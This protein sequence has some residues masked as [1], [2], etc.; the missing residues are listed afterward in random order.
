[1]SEKVSIIIPNKNQYELLKDCIDSIIQNTLYLDY[2]ILIIENG[3]SD[4]D[5]LE[6]YRHLR[7][8]HLDISV[9]P[10]RKPFNFSEINNFAVNQSNG[11]YLLFLNNDTKVI[12]SGWLTEMVNNLKEDDIGA[13]GAALLYK[14]E[15]IQ[16]I[17]VT[18]HPQYVAFHHNHNSPRSII[19][20]EFD[21]PKIVDAVTGA[22]LLTSKYI[23]KEVDGFD[24]NLPL[25][26]NDV[27]FCMKLRDKGYK[28]KWTPD[29][30]LYHYESKTRGYEDTPEKMDKLIEASNY[31]R[32]K[33]KT[34]LKST[35]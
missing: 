32:N 19:Q 3:S 12:N 22:C 5:I 16:H 26:Y 6:Y 34:K 21:S 8:H 4:A 27:D 15:K 2:E 23:F 9:I 13:V 17:G 31:M 30:L 7:R 24:E 14:D 20:E 33:W 11:K 29:C 1:M 25:A 10:F 35:S 18:I 28:I